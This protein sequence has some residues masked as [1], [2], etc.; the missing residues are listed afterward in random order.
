MSAVTMLL[1]GLFTKVFGKICV[2]YI[3]AVGTAILLM[4][5]SVYYRLNGREGEVVLD[6]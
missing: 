2:I 5:S 4:A 6:Y 1:A 3:F